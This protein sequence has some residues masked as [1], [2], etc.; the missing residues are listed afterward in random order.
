M[1]LTGEVRHG[2]ELLFPVLCH[3]DGLVLLHQSVSG[4]PLLSS[5]FHDL[6]EVVGLLRV[7]DVE[8]VVPWRTLALRI[9]V[10]EV[11]HED[12][13]LRHERVDVLDAQL[14]VLRDLDVPDLVLLVEVLLTLDHLLQPIL[15]ADTVIREV[16][17]FYNGVSDDELCY[18]RC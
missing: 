12:A 9:F 18:L 15:V 1:A 8:E 14:L 11:T 7:Q 13:V 17:L 10:R 6:P 5:M 3:L 2:L 4:H 16:E